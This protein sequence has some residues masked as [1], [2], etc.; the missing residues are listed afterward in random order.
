MPLT[1]IAH[2]R[3]KLL[4]VIFGPFGNVGGRASGYTRGE[5][6]CTAQLDLIEPRKVQR[7]FLLFAT[8]F[9]R[10]DDTKDGRPC[11]KYEH[12]QLAAEDDQERSGTNCTNT[13]AFFFIDGAGCSG[14]V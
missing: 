5:G 14:A 7:T 2:A 3:V 8:D 12:R 4:P 6:N 11:R 9:R 10:R 13:L 1:E